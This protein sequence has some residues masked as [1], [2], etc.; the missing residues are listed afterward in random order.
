MPFVATARRLVLGAVLGGCVIGAAPRL[1][2]AQGQPLTF[3]EVVELRRRG[4]STRQILRSA[5]Q[6]CIAFPVT[7]SVARAIGVGTPDTALI[8]GL[9]ESCT[10][11]VAQVELPPGVLVDD[12]FSSLSGLQPFT[13]ADKLCTAEPSGGGL[14]VANRRTTVGCAIEYP[15]DIGDAKNEAVRI[16]LAVA[17][18]IGQRGAMAGLGFGKDPSSW[19]QYSFGLTSDGDVELCRSVGGRCQR[20]LFRRG[21]VPGRPRQSSDGFVHPLATTLA[22][23]IRGRELALYVGDERVGVHS[24]PDVVAGSVSLGVGSRATAVFDRLR[25][26]RV[27]DSVTV[28]TRGGL[29]GRP[30]PTNGPAAVP[31]GAPAAARAPAAASTQRAGA[32]AVRGASGRALR[33]V[34]L[35]GTTPR[36]DGLLGDVAWRTADSTGGFIQYQ[37][38]A[39]AP[40]SA[41]TVVRVLYGSGAIYVAAQL[42]DA[43]PDSIVRRLGDRDETVFSDWFYVYLDGYLDRRSGFAF[44]VNPEGVK[45]DA[46]LSQD[47]D[48]DEAWD[49]VWDAAAQVDARGWTVEMR[50]PLSQLR[51][52]VGPGGTGEQRW[53]VNFRRWIARRDEISDWAPIDRNAGRFVSQFGELRG[54]RDFAAPRRVELQ[55]YS[56]ARL[57]RAPGSESDP[58]YRPNDFY[59]SVGTDVK[60]RFTPSVTLTAT[61]NPDFGQ[62]EA[63]RSVV[64][65]GGDYEN[66]FPEK[67]PFFLEG[68]NIFALDVGGARIFHSRNIGELPRQTNPPPGGHIYSPTST[69][70]LGAAK[71]TGQTKGRWT[72]GLMEAVTAPE[73]AQIADA[74]GAEL[75]V[76]VAPLTNFAVARVTK[77]MRGGASAI[78]GIATAVTRRLDDPALDTLAAAGYVAGLDTRHRFR[79]R[80]E[81]RAT[82]LGSYVEGSQVAMRRLQR[83]HERYFQRPD[84]PHLEYDST[85]TSLTGMSGALSLLGFGKHW[86]LEVG[87]H[88]RSPGFEVNDLGFLPDADVASQFVFIGYDQHNPGPV[89]RR[90]TLGLNQSSRWSFGGERLSQYFGLDARFELPSY[91]GLQL[92]GTR[93]LSALHTRMLGGGP[94]L[95][96]PGQTGGYFGL[97]TDTRRRVRADVTVRGARDDEAGGGWVSGWSSLYVRPARRLLLALTPSFSQYEIPWQSLGGRRIGA[98]TIYVAGHLRMMNASLTG[99]VIYAVSPTLSLQLYSQPFL[100]AFGY[101]DF[102]EMLDPH[103]VRFVDRFRTY[104]PSEIAYDAAAGVYRIDR[105]ADGTADISVSRPDFDFAEMRSQAVLTWEYRRGS[106]LYL[107]W[108]QDRSRFG[109]EGQFDVDRD[110]AGLLGFSPDGRIPSRNEFVVKLSYWLG[111]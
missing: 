47:T 54:L 24:A 63:D 80:F 111:R 100:S 38:R 96:I 78:G 43:H 108:R 4:V 89:F 40:A 13:A 16:E 41:R 3:D 99:R 110:G 50:I 68:S 61:L 32:P 55:P 101:G 94:A 31:A 73:Q 21:P 29:A 72:F 44:G 1:A 25:V 79:E 27:R 69:T 19:N 5:H 104:E 82:L 6:Y 86:S 11:P 2:R 83:R 10:A 92:G 35:K 30:L 97:W 106:T 59:G 7:D 45:W 28:A 9:R 58:F 39:G 88:A 109:T 98:D 95:L 53:G 15:V 17:E 8:A 75:S 48:V 76:P 46:A 51:F 22:V 52:H 85:R 70:I 36:V 103:A 26:L 91:W 34:P 42:Y 18:V 102:K 64:Y 84:A 105:N 62:V 20:L 65:R 90:W 71:L 60:F 37:P 33:A 87:G 66:F 12:D 57:T 74:Q 49:A 67:R 93:Q 77:Q 23:E 81:V 56:V 14:R 107:V